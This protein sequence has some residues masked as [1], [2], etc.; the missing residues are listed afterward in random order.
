MNANTSTTSL[1][2][3]LYTAQQ[4]REGEAVAA[5]AANI[6][7]FDLMEKAG[8]AVFERLC[9]LYPNVA[10]LLVCC[11]K[12]NNGG[13]G[14]I[15]ARLAREQGINVTLWQI[16]LPDALQGDAKSAM[17]R[18]VDSG[19]E[20]SA[21]TNHVPDDTDVIVDAILGTG[22]TGAPR[23][24]YNHVIDRVNQAPCPVLSVDIPSG[25]CADTGHVAGE[26]I[27]AK[28][29]VTFIAMKQGLVTGQARNCV[30]EL[31]FA[32]LDLQ[33]T[34]EQLQTPNA[35][36]TQ[37]DWLSVIP[38]RS[39]IAHKGSNGK[40][41]L[42]GGNYGMSGAAILASMAS[43]A[44]G[45]GLVAALCHKDSIVPFRARCLEA[46][47]AE[48]RADRLKD[49]LAWANVLCL[50]PGLGRD[51][52]AENVFHQVDCNQVSF[53]SLQSDPK[54]AQ[55][56][57]VY[58]A[59]ALYW[60]ARLSPA[61]KKARS[62]NR[63]LTPHAGEAARLLGIEVDEVES[64]RYKAANDLQNIYGGVV[65]LKGAG[66]IVCDGNKRIVCHAGNPGMASGGM[67]DVL[68]G[69]ISALLAQR[70][71]LMQAAV[72]GTLLHSMAADSAA[73][74]AGE[75]GLLASEV[76][77]YVRKHINHR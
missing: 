70:V 67:G 76:I 6:P 53:T 30:G 37:P 77:P 8:N 46:M 57:R 19:G 45:V 47:V 25:L 18:Y 1:P 29:T 17:L 16:G 72:L 68:A 32:G 51:N 44:T 33:D 42:I 14:Y 4:V 40:L 55:L 61:N 21:P 59:D 43:S 60:L 73:N 74:D 52:W 28:H 54:C 50:G 66:S 20:I 26:V 23:D 13:D 64:N 65:V 34:F 11:G 36:L 56:K 58:D 39:R 7:M 69:V 35:Y 48:I 41:C 49:K 27:C 15:I 5:K 75:I 9:V 2:S 63:I 31:L 12:G 3:A 10:N 22:I 71:P 38:E 24:F 62:E